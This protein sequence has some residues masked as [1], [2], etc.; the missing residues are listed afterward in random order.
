MGAVPTPTGFCGAPVGVTGYAAGRFHRTGRCAGGNADVQQALWLLGKVTPLAVLDIA[1]VTLIIYGFLVLIRGT[2][3]D[4]LVR[5]ALILLLATGLLGSWLNLTMLN[6][7]VQNSLPAVL[8]SLPVVFQPELRRVLEQLGRTGNI[9]AGP[10]LRVTA[11][12]GMTVADEV[13]KACQMLVDRGYGALIVIERVTGLEEYVQS[14]TRLDAILSADLLNQV[15]FKGSPLH[16]GAALVR[17]DRV[18]AARCLLPL[19]EN[20]DLAP[21][22]GTRHRAA[23]GITESTD[24]VCVVVSEETGAVS[25]CEHGRIQR[26]PD[27][28]HLASALLQLVGSP[29]TADDADQV[30]DGSPRVDSLI[31]RFP[32]LGKVTR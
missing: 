11:H 22:V 25:I 19:S 14:A 1:L 17:G 8:V 23:V 27:A 29:R 26:I 20:H 30:P 7:L 28:S 10:R 32:S 2:Q 18:V 12:H 16:D 9:L 3:A 13:A 4:Q 6:W 21:E 5:G 15:F 31:S 24:A